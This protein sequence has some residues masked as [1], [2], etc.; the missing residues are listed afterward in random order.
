MD[1]PAFLFFAAVLLGAL[2]RFMP[3]M[4]TGFPVN[5]GGMFYQMVRDLQA[6]HYLLPEVT[7]YN[8]LDI[9]YAYPPFG[10]YLASLLSDFGRLPLLTIFLWLPPFLSLLAIPA[11]YRFAR[12][13]FADD[14]RAALAALLF[15]LTPGGYGWHIMGGGLTR[16]PGI[17]FLL[18]AASQAY[19]A[20]R[21]GR[22]RPVFLA[23]LFGGLAVL[24]HPEV[25]L[26]TAGV[27]AL[28]WLFLGRTRRGAF[29]AFLIAAGVLLL[30][31]PWWATVLA[32]HGLSPFLSAARTGLHNTA[33]WL[34]FL[35]DSFSLS[36][37]F[38]FLALLRLAGLGYA[39]ACR[40]WLLP[41]L[42]IL[43]YLVD[44]RSA[45]SIAIF[46]LSMLAALAF[47]DGLPAILRWIRRRASI[48]SRLET[49]VG[50]ATL[51]ILLFLQF[52][53][54]GL[55]NYRLINTTLTSD[56]RQAMD[57][58][59]ENITPG[60]KFFLL[61]GR[62]NPMNDPAQEWF[63]TLSSQHSQT[64]LQGYEWLLGDQFLRRMNDLGRLQTCQDFA[65]LDMWSE[66]TELIFDDL[67]I[68][69]P[70]ETDMSEQ[71]HALRQLA[72]S[73]GK[74]GE[75]VVIYQ[76]PS[77]IIFARKISASCTGWGSTQN[78][79]DLARANNNCDW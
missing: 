20:F 4:V 53:D 2:L 64:T 60:K 34:K 14:L 72:D 47:L 69:I 40:R 75:F 32:Q 10:L 17:L 25:G 38:P 73:L 1:W 52:V 15:A 70:P 74:S 13:I 36:G 18:L 7:T 62:E 46:P 12:A 63:P 59:R 5:D 9:P 79:S 27:C 56:E 50:V 16:S 28:L 55:Y 29:H 30:A 26:Q 6:N 19:A 65:C 76:N 57:W 44:P 78:Q 24:S 68:R 42:T 3:A 67:W 23:S 35:T 43:P 21:D 45:P 39:L 22:L 8:A 66:R 58:V 11:F 51:V 41:A 49:R 31:A 37:I 61:T 71:A 77:T 48:P 54:C 33:F